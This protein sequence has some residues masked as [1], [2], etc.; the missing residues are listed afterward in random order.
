M[1]LERPFSHRKYI[2][3]ELFTDLSAHH[4]IPTYILFEAPMCN[5]RCEG[6]E[7]WQPTVQASLWRSFRIFPKLFEK[8]CSNPPIWE[9]WK[10]QIKSV[11]SD[12]WNQLLEFCVMISSIGFL[13]INHQKRTAK[14]ERASACVCPV[15]TIG[16][17]GVFL[18][19]SRFW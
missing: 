15:W 9:K 12:K 6:F 4:P 17:T 5:D 8:L 14:R 7:F 19:F 2:L 1:G 3:V 10:N 13:R 16:R 18:T 11:E